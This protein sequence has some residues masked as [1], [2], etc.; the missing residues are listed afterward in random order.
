MRDIHRCLADLRKK[1]TRRI[2]GLMSGTSADGITAAHAE[3]SGTGD[4]AEVNLIGYKTY[5]YAV[6]VRERIF[7][8]FNP[9]QGTVQDVCEMN[10]VLGEVF[11]EAVNNLV[12]DLG[13]TRKD[14]DLIGSH[15]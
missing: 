4:T 11:A 1:E 13:I 7:S 3:I 8:L 6:D 12:A 2:I 9:G 10:F 14:V 15:G 5:P